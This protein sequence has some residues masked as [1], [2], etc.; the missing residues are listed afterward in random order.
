MTLNHSKKA[1]PTKFVTEHTTAIDANPVTQICTN[2]GGSS[3]A[4]TNGV[5]EMH[6]ISR[7][8]A[9]SSIQKGRQLKDLL[10]A[11]LIGLI[12][13][14]LH[15]VSKRFDL[16]SFQQLAVE[17]LR[18]L[19]LT[20]RGQMIAD[21][22][23]LH[24]S[25]TKA[26][27]SRL[28]IASL[29]P[30]LSQTSGNGLTPFFY[31][32]HSHFVASYGISDFESGMQLCHELT[33]R[34]TAEFCIRPFL[35]QHRDQALKQLRHWAGDS[36]PHVRRL[37]SEGTR[38]RLPWAM[39]LTEFQQDPELALPLLELLKDDI[40]LYVRRSVANHLGDMAKDHP[41]FTFAVCD[42]WLD[43]LEAG[44]HSAEKMKARC[45]II[46]HAVR[47]PAKHAVARAL[48]LRARAK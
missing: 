7:F 46:R 39:R 34:F 20:Q 32:P 44:H 36:N 14:S 6:P 21:V 43:E 42:R 12:G 18:N 15:R 47:H 22:M 29:G 24:L 37:V 41:E 2:A 38:P 13:E 28:L 45:W 31:L 4:D 5:S 25:G 16:N 8:H 23:A 27:S 9:P 1:I 30:E 48:E 35:L 11:E 33:R 19:S 3:F 26:E 10:D 40:E 17:Q